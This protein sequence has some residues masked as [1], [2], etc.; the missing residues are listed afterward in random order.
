MELSA[1]RSGTKQL[2]EMELR[3]LIGSTGIWLMWHGVVDKRGSPGVIHHMSELL[4]DII[5]PN[6]IHCHNRRQPL[7][8]EERIERWLGDYVRRPATDEFNKPAGWR[9][10]VAYEEE[11]NTPLQ[12]LRHKGRVKV[13]DHG[14]DPMPGHSGRSFWRCAG[15]R[16]SGQR[17]SP[18]CT[19]SFDEDDL[20]CST[21]E[22]AGYSGEPVAQE[23]SPIPQPPADDEE[24]SFTIPTRRASDAERHPSPTA[25]TSAST[26]R[27]SA[28]AGSSIHVPPVVDYFMPM[29]GRRCEQPAE[30]AQTAA[31]NSLLAAQM[32]EKTGREK[33]TKQKPQATAESASRCG[34]PTTQQPIANKKRRVA[35]LPPDSSDEDEVPGNA[36]RTF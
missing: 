36:N 8:F 14:E 33:V 29:E 25:P 26:T 35:V 17:T 22:H 13:M 11:L 24:F 23:G 28:K 5:K 20:P 27:N 30:A 9:L 34:G 31:I 21:D 2:T 19:R 16:G 15:Q 12:E 32:K 6:M 4:H 1:G 10:Q 7:L 18:P 3:P